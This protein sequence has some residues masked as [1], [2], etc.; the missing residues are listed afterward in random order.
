MHN[1][2]VSNLE[3]RSKHRLQYRVPRAWQL[4]MGMARIQ[5]ASLIYVSRGQVSGHELLTRAVLGRSSSQ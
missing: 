3:L 2:V 1:D 5:V 4:D